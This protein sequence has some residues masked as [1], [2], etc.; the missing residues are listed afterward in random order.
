MLFLT[1]FVFF[2][3]SALRNVSMFFRSEPSWQ[4]IEPLR[5]IGW[6]CRK[7]YYLIVSKEDPRSAK[8]ILSWVS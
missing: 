3:E 5:D 4:V 6:R 7:H 1:I 8:H 2:L